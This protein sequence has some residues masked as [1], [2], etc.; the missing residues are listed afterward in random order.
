MNVYLAAARDLSRA[1]M[2][3]ERALQARAP[4][5]VTVVDQEFRADLVVLHT[6][7][8]PETLEAIKRIRDRG[9]QYAIIQYC[10]RTTQEPDTR[11]WIEKVW[12]DAK[13]V[14][15]YY[16]L[17][18]LAHNDGQAEAFASE[19]KF[20][21]APLGCESEVFYHAPE[22][23]EKPYVV[24]TSGYVAE[25]ECVREAAM[26]AQ[27]VGRL[28]FHLG[29]AMPFGPHVRCLLGIPD[30]ALARCYA[31]SDWVAGLRRIEGFELPAIEGLL[32]GARPVMFDEPHYTRWFAPWAV[33]IPEENHL[34]VAASLET[35]FR[36]GPEPVTVEERRA[37]AERF[38]WN[39]IAAG[40]WERAL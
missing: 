22:V 18:Q 19:V 2:R 12:R 15:S 40:F 38:D 23:R 39:R 1:M 8:M 24:T 34:R 17:P 31:S 20:Y 32:C 7:G 27:A 30:T 37:A 33:F 25:T 16:N 11:H 3:V 29:P 6:I 36:Q 4:E 10:L 35:L 5:G 26:A 21:D 14:W 28:Q 13:V 9:Q